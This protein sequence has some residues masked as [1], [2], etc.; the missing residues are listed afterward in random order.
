MNTEPLE[1]MGTAA[2]QEIINEKSVKILKQTFI[3]TFFFKFKVVVILHL[4][5]CIV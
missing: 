5:L 3:V 1:T 4:C 2:S